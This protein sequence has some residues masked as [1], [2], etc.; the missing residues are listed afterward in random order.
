MQ[1]SDMQDLNAQS[2]S[3]FQPPSKRTKTTHSPIHDSSD[4]SG[5]VISPSTWDQ[6]IYDQISNTHDLP[7]SVPDKRLCFL[8]SS[9]VELDSKLDQTYAVPGPAR[10][11]IA[12]H[13][14]LAD[15]L[16]D[17]AT[18]ES[19]QANKVAAIRQH[20]A[21]QPRQSG[22]SAYVETP[23]PLKVDIQA[24]ING[25]GDEYLHD[26]DIVCLKVMDYYFDTAGPNAIPNH[27]AYNLSL[28]V[29]QSS[30]M[31]KTRMIY[32]V[33][34]QRMTFIF[35][36]R[37]DSPRSAFAYPPPNRRVRKFLTQRDKTDGRIKFRHAIFFITLFDKARRRL[38]QSNL[39][40]QS[41]PTF[42][43]E[44]MKFDK[45]RNEDSELDFYQEVVSEAEQSINVDLQATWSKD[46]SERLQN[47]CKSFVS[48][49]KELSTN[50]HKSH[51]Y[52]VL[53]FDE[54]HTLTS[55]PEHDDAR[56]CSNY[57]ILGSLLNEINTQPIFTLFL[58]TNSHLHSLAAPWPDQPSL[59][60]AALER[61]LP[62]F[63]E[64]PFDVYS[65][66]LYGRIKQ[67]NRMYPTLS[68]LC[69]IDV[70]SA[71]G[72]PLWHSLHRNGY[73]N[74]IDL[75]MHKLTTRSTDNKDAAELACVSLRVMLVF[76]TTR[77][78]ARTVESKLVE[79]FMR[80]V[81]AVPQDL[82]KSRA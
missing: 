11:C 31:G 26:N 47:A 14:D 75:A 69:T 20:P 79:Y 3:E 61:I 57:H 9:I 2:S 54:A 45:E 44:D 46:T 67:G 73:T 42:W 48:K 28:S 70:I 72:R 23:E 13:R 30:G 29:V 43:F 17:M 76:D 22:N 16:R 7:S 24:V 53:A 64:L 58:S 19:Y 68:Q 10:A 18:A 49:L 77:A 36:L 1:D 8:L 32:R 62:P 66:G 6:E 50:L 15:L 52:C 59:R 33:A 37:E 39:G 5:A 60:A 63:T 27:Q 21:I 56:R 38:E 71:F 40:T 4:S 34:L 78:A 35:N 82:M 80:V 51:I 55:L 81:I 65:R 12:G 25:F 41:L 74:V